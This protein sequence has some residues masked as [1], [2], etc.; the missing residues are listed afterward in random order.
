MR[1]R[2]LCILVPAL[3]WSLFFCLF[4]YVKTRGRMPPPQRPLKSA[5]MHTAPVDCSCAVDQEGARVATGQLIL[6]R[7]SNAFTSRLETCSIRFRSRPVRRTS[8][9][10]RLS[11]MALTTAH[12]CGRCKGFMKLSEAVARAPRYLRWSYRK[13]A[14]TLPALPLTCRCSSAVED[15]SGPCPDGN[16]SFK[17]AGCFSKKSSAFGRLEVFW[18]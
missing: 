9:C 3:S 12:A 7:E 6:R 10:S 11:C 15:G 14:L 1:R 4:F 2:L 18:F 13:Q 8:I 17:P 16:R 5:D